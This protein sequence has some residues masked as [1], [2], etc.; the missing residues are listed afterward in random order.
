MSSATKVEEKEHF[1]FLTGQDR[2]CKKNEQKRNVK[3]E[4]HTY[5]RNCSLSLSWTNT[6]TVQGIFLAD[7]SLD[8][9]KFGI[10][11][12]V[13]CAFITRWTRRDTS[14]TRVV[15]EM[16]KG[17][18]NSKNFTLKQWYSQVFYFALELIRKFLSEIH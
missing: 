18:S 6:V 3:Y 10:T 14:S 12:H 2:I 9:P 16:E 5:F 1:H 15:E 8:I 13:K 4:G 17:V 11:T 7:F